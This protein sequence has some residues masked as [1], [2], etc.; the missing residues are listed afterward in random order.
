MGKNGKY[1]L[2]MMPP[3]HTK[4]WIGNHPDG[5]IFPGIVFVYTWTC[6]PKRD[7]VSQKSMLIDVSCATYF[8]GLRTYFPLHLSTCFH[9]AIFINQRFYMS[10][11]G[12]V[13]DWFEVTRPALIG[14]AAINEVLGM[15]QI[16]SGGKGYKEGH[17]YD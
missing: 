15:N 9:E 4:P 5:R 8:L 16:H 10:L 12:T 3:S 14:T 2:S 6:Q 17:G 1:S 7:R 13:G 11:I